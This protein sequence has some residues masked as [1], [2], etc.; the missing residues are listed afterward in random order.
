M[1]QS[2]ANK[3]K[4][5]IRDY[6]NLQGCFVWIQNNTPAMTKRIN[7]THR[8]VG[9]I[10]GC[11]RKG[12]H[13]EVEV[14]IDKDRQSEFQEQHEIE[15]KSRNSIYIIAKDFGEFRKDFSLKIN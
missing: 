9:D 13:I 2:L 10:I 3:L 11:T 8:G 7:T 15:L 4:L 12:R 1:K 14:N 6:L 5:Q